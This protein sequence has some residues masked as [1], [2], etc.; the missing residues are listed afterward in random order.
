MTS[1]LMS[2]RSRAVHPTPRLPDDRTNPSTGEL[3][4]P[5]GIGLA[6]LHQAPI[7]PVKCFSTRLRFPAWATPRIK[8]VDFLLQV[9]DLILFSLIYSLTTRS[10]FRIRATFHVEKSLWSSTKT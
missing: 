8:N 1:T 2:S 9:L 3:R 10:S 6:Q 7:P 5:S 4:T